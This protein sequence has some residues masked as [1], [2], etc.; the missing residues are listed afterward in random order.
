MNAVTVNASRNYQVLIGPGLLS[1]LG[2][3]AAALIK[4][5][6]ACI[7][8]DSN[9]FPL[10]GQTAKASLE[11]AGFSVFEFVFPAGEQS[12][13]AAVWLEL[14]NVLA[15]HRLT[16]ADAIVALG[17]GVT[18]DMAGFAAAT[19]L[20]GVAY[21]QVPT[22]LLAMVDSSVG[23]KTAIDL[24]AGKNLCGAFCQ[25]RLVLCDTDCMSTLPRNV[26]LGGCAEV[27]KYGVLGSRELFDRLKVGPDHLDWTWVITKCVS[28]KR[29]VV[30]TDEFD[31]GLR[32]S[33][34]L[35]HTLGHAV[36]ANSGFSLSHGQAVAIGMSMIC[37]AAVRFG[38]CSDKAAEEIIS[39]LQTYDLPVH[40]DQQPETILSTALGDKKRQGASLTL[41]VPREIGR[42]DL[43]A[44]SVEELP[45][46]IG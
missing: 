30:E 28:M 26:L 18:G 27:I 23:G 10:Y 37:R 45:R 1:S 43:H 14:L 24:P 19:Y 4:G 9:V 42:C 22:S 46:W 29:D 2:K 21:I 5:R 41:I 35:G 7:V 15:Q 13:C 8:S 12:K 11:Q 31:T 40:T 25:P 16:R 20:R 38:L 34:N 33:L 3:E 36:E 39:L 44:I 17:G 6:T 32:Q